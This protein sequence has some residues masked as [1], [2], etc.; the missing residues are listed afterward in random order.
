[1]TRLVVISDAITERNQQMDTDDRFTQGFKAGAALHV[2][3]FRTGAGGRPFWQ[4][5]PCPSWCAG[6]HSDGESYD[7]RSHYTDEESVKLS[8]EQFTG[9]GPSELRLSLW[10][11]YREHEPRL[12]LHKDDS[13]GVYLTLSEAIR[14]SEVLAQLAAVAAEPD[15]LCTSKR[16]ERGLRAAA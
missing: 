6:Q 4:D 5:T 13:H 16:P 2:G 12:S 7:D 15:E 14:L 9:S 11:H 10:Q 1:L 8:T 3:R